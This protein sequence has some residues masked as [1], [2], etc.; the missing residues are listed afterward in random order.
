MQIVIIGGSFSG[1]HCAL[2]AAELYPTDH[3]ILVEKE[4]TLGF[5]PSGLPLYL[6]GDVPSLEK[7]VFTTVEA[8]EEKGIEVKLETDVLH[9]DFEQQR[10]ETS[11]ELLPYDRLV[12]ATGSSQVSQKIGLDHPGVLTYKNYKG[13]IQ[14]LQRIEESQAVAIVGAGQVGMELADALRYTGKQVHVFDSMGYP[15]YKYF[16]EDILERFVTMLKEQSNVIFHF[17]ET[18]NQLRDDGD[19][20]ELNIGS[21]RILVESVSLGVNVRPD[22]N[23]YQNQ[24]DTHSDMTIKVSEYLET[25]QPNV[26]AIGDLI[27]VPSR[28]LEQTVYLPLINN[29]VRTAL[30]CAENL[31]DKTMVFEGTSRTIGTKLFDHY[32]ASCGMIESDSFLYP[33]EVAT[34]CQE[35]PVTVLSRDTVRMK[36]CYNRET[37]QILGVQLVSKANILDR[38]NL[39]ALSIDQ[40]LTLNDM[41]QRDYFFHPKYANATDSFLNP[42]KGC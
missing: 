39:Y 36:I 14:A 11:D 17:N 12:L 20:I 18:I 4:R 38:I 16:D 34:I 23:L 37:T 2:R 19:Q 13:A 24:L 42:R 3:I 41:M 5:L 8:L 6:K 21:E 40:G 15:F 22:L 35:V 27:Q 10:I 31:K 7:A 25:S 29:A 30:V 26:F 9:I 32:L 1:V 28:L 33:E